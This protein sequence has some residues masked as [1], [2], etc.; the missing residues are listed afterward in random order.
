MDYI[1]FK[2]SRFYVKLKVMNGD[3]V[4]EDGDVI[5]LVNLFLLLFFSQVDVLMQNKLINSLGVYY[6]YFS[7]L[8]IFINFGIDVKF[9]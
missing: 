9:L 3:I 1:D 2:R 8:N 7:M 6:L 4:F 5:G